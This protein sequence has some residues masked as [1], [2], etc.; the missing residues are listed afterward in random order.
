MKKPLICAALAVTVGLPALAESLGSDLFQGRV[1]F[2]VQNPDPARARASIG[3]KYSGLLHTVAAPEDQATYGEVY[4]YGF[5]SGTTYKSATDLKPGY[6]VYLHPNWY[7]WKAVASK[8]A[9]RA[10]GPE[11]ATG[12]PN[13]FEAGDLRTAWA[14]LGEDD[15][16]EW[17]LLS[18]AE[19]V[20]PS[21]VLVHETYNPGA[22]VKVAA[23][24]PDGSEVVVWT[25]KDPL[26][27]GSGK[28]VAIIPFRT[29]FKTDRL[30]LYLDSK[31]VKG[32][33]E[34]D[35]VGL[36]DEFGKTGWAVSAEASSTYATSPAPPPGTARP[37]DLRLLLVR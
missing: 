6:W 14:S 16:D 4:D 7:V 22:L 35:A 25:G 21:A 11:Q 28:G 17:L 20:T 36:V 24:R 5:W 2:R 19:A 32:W 9:G 12:E 1:P 37:E 13:T 27:P 8:M 29:E 3:G 26:E 31:G 15:Q 30:K 10:W 34:I 18:Y 33:N 23:L